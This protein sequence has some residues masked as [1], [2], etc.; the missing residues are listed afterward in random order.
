VQR[1]Q[2]V[3]SRLTATEKNI[4]SMKDKLEFNATLKTEMTALETKID[5]N[6]THNFATLRNEMADHEKKVENKLGE[7]SVKL[8]SLRNE[9]ADHETKIDNSLTLKFSHFESKSKE[10][11]SDLRTETKEQISDLRTETRKNMNLIE[12]DF[13]LLKFGGAFSI[14]VIIGL[15]DH[16][17]PLWVFISKLPALLLPNKHPPPPLYLGLHLVK[18]FFIPFWLY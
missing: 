5:N 6:L 14:I 9:M 3:A 16:M 10:Q 2:I 1:A 8:V 11:I 4:T 12:S 17:T 18:I 7:L 15:T 13:R